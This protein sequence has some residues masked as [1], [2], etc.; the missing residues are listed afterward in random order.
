MI[1]PHRDIFD[2]AAEMEKAWVTNNITLEVQ[3]HWLSA[4][5]RLLPTSSHVQRLAASNNIEELL[6]HRT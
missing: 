3:G 6:V 5:K 4:Q 2:Q 1:Q